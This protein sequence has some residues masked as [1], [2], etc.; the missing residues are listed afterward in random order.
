MLPQPL[1]DHPRST[2][3]SG[4]DSNG[5]DRTVTGTGAALHA[6]ITVGKH[7]L[8]TVRCEDLM[9][10]D[11]QASAAA[12][13]GQRV[14]TQGDDAIQIAKT[15]HMRLLYKNRPASNSI[16][17]AISAPPMVGMAMRISFLTP[18]REV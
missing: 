10:T 11:L 16:R 15:F 4:F 5:L 3:D 12:N 8:F 17:L 13:A 7:N 9:R 14:Q 18:D 2:T 6:G 1:G